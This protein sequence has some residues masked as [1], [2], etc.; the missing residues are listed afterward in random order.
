M[1][2]QKTMFVAAFTFISIYKLFINTF[3]G[4]I[5]TQKRYFFIF[6]INSLI[7]SFFNGNFVFRKRYQLCVNIYVRG[8]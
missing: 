4:I 8:K 1:Y 7:F 6:S 2:N 5:N 3:Y